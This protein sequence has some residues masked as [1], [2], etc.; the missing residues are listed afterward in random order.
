MNEPN[1]FRARAS[2]L[3][4]RRKMRPSF[5]IPIRH[6]IP[7]LVLTA[8]AAA[9]PAQ[10]NTWTSHGPTDIGSI[11]DLA[12]ADSVAYAA[13][14]NGVFRSTDGAASWQR[15]G[16]AG[17]WIAQIVARSGS[18]VVLARSVPGVLY[19]SRDGGVTWAAIPDLPSVFLAAIDPWHPSTLYAATTDGTTRTIWTSTDAA[20]TWQQLSTTPTGQGGRSFEFDSHAIYMIGYD[21]VDGQYKPYKSLDGGVSWTPVSSLVP[22]PVTIAAGATPGVVYAGRDNSFCRSADSAATWTCSSFPQ[23]PAFI[24]ELPGNAS[25]ASVI[26]A[27]ASDGVYMS[28]DGGATWALSDGEFQG[29]Y[30]SA[31]AADASGSLV[32]VGTDTRIFR[33]QDRGKSWMPAG[34]GLQAANVNGLALDPH[35]SSIV[36]AGSSNAGLF[37][38]GDGGFSWLPVDG[39]GAPLS[40]AKLV[41]DPEQSST[42][43][44]GNGS[45]VYR[46]GDS[47]V[48]W[49]SSTL[50]DGAQVS[51]LAVDPSSS[52]RV[53][54]GSY[55]GLFRSDDGAQSWTSPASVA[56]EVYSI[57]FDGKKP[58]TVYAGSYYAVDTGFYGYPFGGALF[59]SRDSGANWARIEHDIGSPVFAIATDPFDDHVLYVG[60]AA[61]VLRSPND[62]V[63]WQGPGAGL[64]S[65]SVS[66]LVADPVRPGSLYTAVD[67]VVYRTIDG[68]QTWQP[69]S[70]GLGSLP[71]QA[72]VISPDGKW[73]HAA[74]G[75]GGVFE[76]DLASAYPCTPS[77]TRLCLVDSRFAVELAAGESPS[78]PG[79]ARSLGD[80]S[81][82]FSL[83]FATGNPDLPEVVVKMFGEGAFGAGGAPVFYASLTTLPYVLTVTDTLTGR[84]EIYA[85]NAGAPLC[86]GAQVPFGEAE[87]LTPRRAPPPG[88]AQSAV[89]LLGGR[90]SV[91]LEARSPQGPTATGTAMASG[92]QFEIFSLPD[93]TGD[94]QFPEVVVKMVDFRAIT[95]KFWFFYTGLTGLDYTLT[96]TDSKT[97]AV[98]TYESPGP[99]CGGADTSAFGD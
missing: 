41:I 89:R 96:V 52:G 14:P 26:L 82:Y 19:A 10:E 66:S 4:R 53:W 77:A 56:Q 30:L 98:R 80:R 27:T 45:T 58:G 90:F 61:G 18:A 95:G 63:I 13:T 60:T 92:D 12:I 47:G 42:L 34:A 55:T 25:G 99:F 28:G 5:L 88:A 3:Q 16:L 93:I 94:P 46:S 8:L 78:N 17:E 68:A 40:V 65:S 23:Y 86:G 51:S 37:R 83:P 20:A 9:A 67:G 24:V 31:L 70:S 2:A 39:P 57:L 50:P 87:A 62:G 49:A 1:D 84:A 76:L 79:S 69:F 35:D 7:A 48:H 44:A 36:W 21:N 74:T 91:T 15:S 72:L 85:S 33:S 29:T 38:S 43:Y 22:Y 97:G 54:A 6:I 73:L 81:G 59:V 11:N 71:V 32:L 64:P 75:G